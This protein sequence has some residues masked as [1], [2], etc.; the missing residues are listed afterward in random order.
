M[1][2]ARKFLPPMPGINPGSQDFTNLKLFGEFES[3]VEPLVETT[4]KNAAQSLMHTLVGFAIRDSAGL[5]VHQPSLERNLGR[6]LEVL[7]HDVAGTEDLY[8]CFKLLHHTLIHVPIQ[9]IIH[10][11]GLHCTKTAVVEPS[12]AQVPGRG[13]LA[14]SWVSQGLAERGSRVRTGQVLHQD[15]DDGAVPRLYLL[16]HPQP[17]PV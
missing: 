15:E 14:G 16:A 10:L 3:L 13:H 7:P 11:L 6:R 17:D 1:N 12:P 9:R 5:K 8:H 4:E 2:K